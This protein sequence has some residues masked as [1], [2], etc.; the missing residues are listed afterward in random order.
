MKASEPSA[1]SAQMITGYL[2]ATR[3][4]PVVPPL[5]ELQ[6][7]EGREMVEVVL[8]GGR[9]GVDAMEMQECCVGGLGSWTNEA[10]AV[11]KLGGEP[12]N[13]STVTSL[14]MATHWSTAL[15]TLLGVGGRDLVV[16]GPGV[17]AAPVPRSGTTTVV[18][19][20]SPRS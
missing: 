19:N 13:S 15:D 20:I 8:C 17:D 11:A 1:A 5:L 14:P 10:L 2:S 9:E 4:N 12:Q 3:D 18:L 6:V 7:G 16:E